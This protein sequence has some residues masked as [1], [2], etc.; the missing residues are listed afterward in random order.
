MEKI[1]VEEIR[2]HGYIPRVPCNMTKSEF[3]ERFVRPMQPAILTGCDYDWL[4]DGGRRDL[5]LRSVAGFYHDNATVDA[6]MAA[7]TEGQAAEK[8]FTLL[9]TPNDY[10]HYNTPEIVS[11][12]MG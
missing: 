4:S 3:T 1:P 11:Q 10:E 6:E 8:S 2:Q 7:E 9:G 5:S 12:F